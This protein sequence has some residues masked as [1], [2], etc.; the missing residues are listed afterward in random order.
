[1]DLSGLQETISTRGKIFPARSRMVGS[2]SGKS[3]IVPRIRPLGGEQIGRIVS[4][5]RHEEETRK[6]VAW[7][8]VCA[9]SRQ[10]QLQKGSISE[11]MQQTAE[12]PVSLSRRPRFFASLRTTEVP[13]ARSATR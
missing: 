7:G 6:R 9:A 8:K 1:M 12:V 5:I 2:V 4:L 11:R 10:F 3:I 13:S